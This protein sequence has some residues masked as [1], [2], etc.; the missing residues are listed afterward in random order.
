MLQGTPSVRNV[1]GCPNHA[2][3]LPFLIVLVARFLAVPSLSTVAA[4][5]QPATELVARYRGA[6][7]RT[8]QADARTSDVDSLRVLLA[9]SLILEYPVTRGR[10]TGREPL[11]ASIRA[12]LG[13]S[14]NAELV[15]RQELVT[16]IAVA[17]T[18]EVRFEDHRGDR[19]QQRS[20][21]GLV[22]Y[23]IADGRIGRIIEYWITSPRQ[24]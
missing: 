9:D 4:Q 18:E 20:R 6:L 15:V 14:R 21:V 8:M 22:V 1:R 12:T 11:L 17:A 3:P 10:I 13:L 16:P 23:E 7:V 5:A 24:P 19:W 2:T